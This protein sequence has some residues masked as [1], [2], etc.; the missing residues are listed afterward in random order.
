[1]RL[2][3]G[4]F[5][6]MILIIIFFHSYRK[7]KDLFSPLCI[8]SLLT[9]LRYVPHIISAEYET[10]TT[11]NAD[12]TLRLFIYETI[13]I[14]SVLLGYWYYNSSFSNKKVFYVDKKKKDYQIRDW[15]IILI[16]V[17]G[18]IGRVQTIIMAGG[19]SAIIQSRA[20]AYASLTDGT[21]ILSML[22]GCSI[23]GAML[24]LDKVI[25]T[26]KKEGNSASFF[27][28]LMVLLLM[29]GL[30]CGSFMIFTSRSPMLEY[31]MFMAFGLNYLWKRIEL[32]S[33]L[34]PKMFI[35][36]LAILL[37]II[38]LPQFRNSQEKVEIDVSNAAEKLFDEFTYVGRDTL[39]YEYFNYNNFWLGKSYTSLLTA[40]VPYAIYKNKPPVDDGIYLSNLAYGHYIEPPASRNELYVK[41]SIPFSTPSIMYANFGVLG[42]FL[43]CFFT[44]ILYGRFY[45]AAKDTQDVMQIIAYQLIVYQL[46][47]SSL[48]TVQTLIPLIICTFIYKILF[49]GKL[50]KLYPEQILDYKAVGE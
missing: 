25:L 36:I 45:K 38:V 50:H 3:Y 19:I 6:G 21:G 39:V 16:F 18:M 5:L 44:G 2:I 29:I 12:N 27:G 10:F 43:G 17:I 48:Q 35:T 15:Q 28:R 13:A 31:L 24:Q 46:E 11:L 34:R 8:F 42:I 9:F 14:F 22:S 7:N 4:L 37:V 30:Y 49:G 41:Y 40:F 20:Q 47:L 33:L 26:K 32:S 1:M 23:I